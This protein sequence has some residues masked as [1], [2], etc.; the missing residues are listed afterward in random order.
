MKTLPL[1]LAI[2]LVVLPL[3]LSY[4]ADDASNSTQT[5]SY[6]E[7]LF[8]NIVAFSMKQKPGW[9]LM[10]NMDYK[11]NAS[12]ASPLN[13]I[14][15][16]NKDKFAA[17]VFEQGRFFSYS[18][19]RY[20]FTQEARWNTQPVSAEEYLTKVFSKQFPNV[21]ATIVEKKLLAD[22]TEAEKNYLEQYRQATYNAIMANNATSVAKT[23]IYDMQSDTATL[24]Y[25][26]DDKDA[27]GK[28]TTMQHR[29]SVILQ[30]TVC[31][32]GFKPDERRTDWSVVHFST[33]TAPKENFN[34]MLQDGTE[35]LSSLQ[36]TDAY[37]AEINKIAQAEKDQWNQ[38]IT[39]SNQRIAE[40]EARLQRAIQATR[41]SQ[42]ALNA[43]FRERNDSLSRIAT[44]WNETIRGVETY[45][46]L[47]GKK[48]E[49]PIIDGN[50]VYQEQG[51]DTIYTSDTYLNTYMPN[52]QG[53]MKEFHQLQIMKH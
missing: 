6:R 35:M 30:A 28:V 25:E 26:W 34:A 7:P 42:D 11:S 21:K 31:A 15:G 52:A 46:T 10:G 37:Q 32:T 23:I 41:E 39:V 40:S 47:D 29:M 45:Q 16:V 2:C 18:P 9:V 12:M 50:K 53:H 44:G 3:N 48:I 49:I 27:D 22:N 17:F 51:G 33:L 20:Q 14:K 8:N 5:V 43:S 4:G 36:R 24:R 38:L 19:A 13:L 1:F